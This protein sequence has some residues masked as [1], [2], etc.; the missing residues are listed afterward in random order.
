MNAHAYLLKS[1]KSYLILGLLCF[2]LQTIDGQ[3]DCNNAFSG[4]N[5]VVDDYS[6]GVVGLLVNGSLEDVIDGD[7][8][9]YAEINTTAAVAGTS[10]ISIKNIE[11]SFSGGRRVGFVVEAVGGLLTT[12]LLEGLQL[13]TYLN[14][15]LQET[16]SFGGGGLL[17]LSLLGSAGGK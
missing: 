12:D 14:N 17:R 7:L 11:S 13:R 15:T 8:N 9:N 6:V 16:V 5:F 3:S 1:L 2:S 4:R 10:L